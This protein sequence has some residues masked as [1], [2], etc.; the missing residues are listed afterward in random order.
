M[1]VGPDY[2]YA[3]IG[4]PTREYGWILSRTCDLDEDTM[5]SIRELLEDQYYDFN[6][7]EMTDQTRN[8][9]EE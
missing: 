5:Q 6:D 1:D 7:F 9:C 2:E 8:G 4:H 3:V